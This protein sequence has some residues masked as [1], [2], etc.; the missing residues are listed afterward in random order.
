[1]TWGDAKAWGRFYAKLIAIAAVNGSIIWFKFTVGAASAQLAGLVD[2]RS[3]GWK[4]AGWTL[5]GTVAV[6][7]ATEL[8]QFLLPNP[9]APTPPD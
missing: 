2:L 4:G 7:I 5:L 3:I 1:M 6:N 9:S 8:G